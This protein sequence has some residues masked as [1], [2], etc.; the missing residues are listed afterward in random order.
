M[1]CGSCEKNK[2]VFRARE[3][4][5]EDVH[6]ETGCECI[7]QEGDEEIFCPR[8]NVMKTP[9]QY[10][11]CKKRRDYFQ[12]WEEGRGPFQTPGSNAQV[13]HGT[14]KT[15]EERQKEKEEGEKRLAKIEKE[16]EVPQ[17]SR[18]LGDTI[19]KITKA[20][21]IRA[22]VDA[23]TKATGKDCGCEGRREWLNNK[24]SYKRKTKGFFK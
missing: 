9:H 22:V 23:F 13:K 12:K 2:T 18:G 21:G 19:E 11:L 15:P 24:V 20:T 6:G 8:H 4:P 16:Q 10:N 3:E 14:V 1:G 5:V 17:K 7:F